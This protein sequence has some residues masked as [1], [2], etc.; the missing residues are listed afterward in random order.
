MTTGSVDLALVR[1]LAMVLIVVVLV[2]MQPNHDSAHR[3]PDCEREKAE[4][5]K[6]EHDDFHADN[7]AGCPWC[8]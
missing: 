5:A 6:R 8:R 4:R 3:C 2:A 1:F 7:V